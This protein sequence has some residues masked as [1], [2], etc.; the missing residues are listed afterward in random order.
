[1]DEDIKTCL[2][3]IAN[4]RKMAYVFADD[5]LLFAKTEKDLE[6]NMS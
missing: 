2:K 6:G 1:M 3:N 5:V 4:Y